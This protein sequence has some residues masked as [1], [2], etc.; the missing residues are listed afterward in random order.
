MRALRAYAHA[1]MRAAKS[2]LYSRSDLLP[3]MLAENAEA[4]RRA[5]QTIGIERDRP[6]FPQ[7]FAR[8]MTFYRT[9]IDAYGEDAHVFVAML[10]L[11]ELENLKLI[12]RAVTRSLPADEW[13][14]YWRDVWD[15]HSCLSLRALKDA[16]SVRDLAE[17]L[18]GTPYAD[19]ARRVAEAH[20]NDLAAAELAFDQWG[21]AML[22]REGLQSLADA[23]NAELKK[24]GPAALRAVLGQA[25]SLSYVR[26][27]RRTTTSQVV[28]HPFRLDPAISILLLA[29]DELRAINRL[30]ES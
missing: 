12:W 23:R 21:T 16:T 26:R 1:R 17:R 10:R 3:L 29:E 14:P 19:I 4:K 20:G 2:R 11:H 30:A 5:L 9:A 13:V 25:E 6:L 15:R 24:R 28:P 8:L 22:V 7:L 18:K 27:R